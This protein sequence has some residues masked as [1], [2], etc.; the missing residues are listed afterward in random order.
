[1]QIQKKIAQGHLLRCEHGHSFV[2]KR[3]GLS[4]ECPKCGETAL[5]T[6]LA[7]AFRL[8]LIAQTAAGAV[9]ESVTA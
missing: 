1:M 2:V 3:L 9:K 5:S 4:V 7:T 6:E 8:G